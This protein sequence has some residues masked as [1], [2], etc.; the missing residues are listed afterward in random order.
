E[1]G[2][3]QDEERSRLTI[4]AEV[5]SKWDSNNAA[6]TRLEQE[7][8][9]GVAGY[10]Y[11]DEF[12]DLGRAEGEQ[13]YIGVVHADGNSIGNVLESITKSYAQKSL[14]ENRNY[15]REL[16]KFSD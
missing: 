16:R 13:S 10:V 15:I 11:P 5:A 12:D 4:S 1:P 7:L 6:K 2:T 8:P 3:A 14:P 9:I